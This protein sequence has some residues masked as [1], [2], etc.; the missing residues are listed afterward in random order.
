MSVFKEATKE[1]LRVQTSYGLLSVEQLWDLSL[2]KLSTII[3][4]LKKSMK[5]F[6]DDELS[7]LDETK[8]VDKQKELTFNVLKEIYVEKKT[9]LDIQRNAASVKEHNEKILRLIHSKQEADLAN[10][11]VEELQSLLK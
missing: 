11:S 2:N 10:K 6:D 7:F 3:K 9:E 4:N 8:V 1:K 5:E